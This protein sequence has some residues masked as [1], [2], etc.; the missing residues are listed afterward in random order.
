LRST[1]RPLEFENARVGRKRS[2]KAALGM[3]MTLLRAAA[4]FDGERCLDD[5]EVLLSGDRITAVGKGL[6]AADADVVTLAGTTLLP[7]LI[8]LHSHV[9]LHPYDQI[10]WNDQ[11]LR[12]SEALRVARAVG[13]LRA[14]LAAGFTTLRD[15]GTEGAGD[16]DV[17]LREAVDRGI[18]EGPRMICVTRAIV[19]RGSYG[20]TGF[21]PHA[22][23][24]QAAEE[25]DGMESIAAATRRQIRAGA[26]WIKVY[27]DYRYGPKGDT[28]PAFSV[29]ELALIV[30]IASDAGCPVAAHATTSEGM[31]RS[32]LAGVATI[33]HGDD[34]N[35]DVFALM[36]ARGV[37]YV[38]TLA[39]SESLARY[40]SLADDDP[41]RSAKRASFVAAR[42]SGVVIANGSDVGVFAHG[43][44]A[45][46]ISLLE[47]HGLTTL[48]ALRAATSVAAKVLRRDDIGVLRPG[49][50]ADLVAIEG[51]PLDDISL[52]RRVRAVWKDGV[53]HTRSS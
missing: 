38:P 29:D 11:V 42:E 2:G 4:V 1:F 46:E 40:R 39:A 30:R 8:D 24:P 10:S 7:G 44:N 48:E 14:T 12:E 34:G 17:G 9:L 52:L 41:R 15:L 18:I 33:E 49:A 31:R 22:C 32:A 23:T 37:A 13:A 43:D 5:T 51:D 27:A 36:A 25:V 45:R 50:R 3:R 28:R 19:A 26:Q 16:A 20:P 35:A 21:A 53:R 47:E 6:D